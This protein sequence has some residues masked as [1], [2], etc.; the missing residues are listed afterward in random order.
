MSNK[1]LN[2]ILGEIQVDLS[3]IKI[4]KISVGKIIIQKNGE[5]RD[6]LNELLNTDSSL[7]QKEKNQEE[8]FVEVI[9][10]TQAHEED[11]SQTPSIGISKIIFTTS[12]FKIILKDAKIIAKKLIIKTEKKEKQI[13]E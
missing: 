11:A 5:T 9:V 10:S 4:D 8:N 12:E 13:G 1:D 7:V 6:K 2:P 3:L